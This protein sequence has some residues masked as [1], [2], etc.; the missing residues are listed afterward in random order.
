MAISD[1]DIKRAKAASRALMESGP[2]A[3]AARYDQRRAR[4]VVGLDNGIEIVFAPDLAEGL[5]GAAPAELSAIEISPTGLGLHWPKLDA[6]LY[7]PALL[8]GVFG[9]PRWMAGAMGRLGG[10]SRSSAKVAAARANGRRGGRPRKNA[11]DVASDV[12]MD[13]ND[14]RANRGMSEPEGG[15]FELKKSMAHYPKGLDGRM[16]DRD[17]EI[18]QKRSDTLVGTLRK[19]YGNNFAQ[20]YRSDA[21]L[22]TV[23][24]REG[25]ETLDQLRKKR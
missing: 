14:R 20:G 15:R 12:F 10:V 9:S 2:R 5:A 6:D 24:K 1:K 21:K 13:E 4:I 25:V 16:R 11:D 7:L 19:E 23:L 3:T 22:G 8:N 18:R 17:G